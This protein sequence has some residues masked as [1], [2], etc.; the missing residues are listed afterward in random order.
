MSNGLTVVGCATLDKRAARFDC[1]SRG[2]WIQAGQQ[3]SSMHDSVRFWLADWFIYGREKEYFETHAQLELLGLEVDVDQIRVYATV[4]KELA[5]S[6]RRDALSFNHHKA[7]ADSGEDG[8]RQLELL[9]IAADEEL[10]VPQL[11]RR[12]AEKHEDKDPK[13][14]E[15]VRFVDS[16][17]LI[18]DLVWFYSR[19]D[20]DEW[21][22]ERLAG[23]RKALAGLMVEMK[24]LGI[25]SA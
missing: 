23:E 2:E 9:Q 21:D 12:I 17:K 13:P 20:F 10:T 4:A 22:D 3:L 5:P 1:R 15:T 8:N 24:R 6:K 19:Q 11:R 16:R 7:V 14:K 25:T 18:A